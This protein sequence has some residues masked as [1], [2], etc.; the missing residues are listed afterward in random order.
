M[1]QI[2]QQQLQQLTLRKY[3]AAW[4]MAETSV[5][6]LTRVCSHLATATQHKPAWAHA[7]PSLN[8]R[9]NWPKKI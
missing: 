7:S 3:L 5:V 8:S 1:T 2:Y 4:V 9:A 6:G